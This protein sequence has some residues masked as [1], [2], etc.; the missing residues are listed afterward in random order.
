[1]KHL[2]TTTTI[3][4]V[5]LLAVSLVACGGSDGD[6]TASDDTVISQEAVAP[7]G[8]GEVA[9]IRALLAS[10]GAP[11]DETT[12]VAE[13]LAGK[14]DQAELKKL[15][16]ATDTEADIDVDTAMAFNDAIM[17]CDLG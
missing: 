8:E 2:R 9:E 4:T 3:A 1:M 11:V 5:A 12:C 15:L 13:E 16:E 6:S 7:F 14:V 10:F 17:A